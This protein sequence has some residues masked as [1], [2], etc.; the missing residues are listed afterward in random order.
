MAEARPTVRIH[1]HRPPDRTDIF[2]QELVHEDAEHTVTLMPR[3]PLAKP[4]RVGGRTVLEDGAPVLWF[5]YPGRMYDVGIFHD[6]HGRRTG[7]YANLLTPVE[8]R[9]RH[10][11]ATTDLFLDVW[12]GADGTACLLDEDELAEAEARGWVD[13]GLATAARTEAERL[14]AA[15]R[16]GE[17]P[18]PEVRRWKLAGLPGT[19]TPG[20]V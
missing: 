10:E 2:V 13:A 8:P 19:P 4:V 9:G 5:T 11:W 18:G 14:L 3:T 6:R 12:V 20:P 1:Y 16:R 7:W 15:A 17:F